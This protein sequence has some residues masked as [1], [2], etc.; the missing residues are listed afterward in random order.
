MKFLHNISAA[1]RGRKTVVRRVSPHN[2]SFKTISMVTN[3]A[4]HAQEIFLNCGAKVV[5]IL[6][7]YPSI[8]V[9]KDASKPGEV[10]FGNPAGY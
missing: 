3:G 6:R 8:V 4:G 2:N 9:G 10:A 7:H 1:G 5:A